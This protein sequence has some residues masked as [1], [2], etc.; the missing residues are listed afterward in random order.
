MHTGKITTD[1]PGLM[2]GTDGT[3][4]FTLEDG[5]VWSFV[6]MEHWNGECVGWHVTKKGDRFAALEPSARGLPENTAVWP[7]TSL[8]A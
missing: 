2:W 8:V 7:S 6:A 1:A 4:I 3:K 5:W